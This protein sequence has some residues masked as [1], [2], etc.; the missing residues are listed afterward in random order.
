MV[1]D[2]NGVDFSE[3]QISFNQI[4]HYHKVFNKINNS[5]HSYEVSIG[6]FPP[7]DIP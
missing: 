7:P 5:F 2:D 1:V 6:L 3:V 4:N